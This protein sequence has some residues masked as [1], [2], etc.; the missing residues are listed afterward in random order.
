M[1]AT[2]F[3]CENQRDESD[4]CDQQQLP[5]RTAVRA[6]Q[7][8]LDGVT[9]GRQLVRVKAE[10]VAQRLTHGRALCFLPHGRGTCLDVV[11][12]W[13]VFHG[14]YLLRAFGDQEPFLKE[15]FLELQ[16]TFGKMNC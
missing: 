11:A 13:R 2:A 4:A 3:P 15:R 14:G 8:K 9:I 7:V 6:S 5:K 16:R 10:I 1:V 12:A